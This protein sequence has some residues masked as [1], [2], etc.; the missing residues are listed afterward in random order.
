MAQQRDEPIGFKTVQLLKDQPLG[1]DERERI[2]RPQHSQQVQSLQLTIQ[3]KDQ[4]IL[5][6]DQA[7]RDKDEAI[8]QQERENSI[9]MENKE[10]EL[11]QKVGKIKHLERQLGE[12]ERVIAQLQKRI[13]ELEQRRPATDAIPTSKE[14]RA[15][16][17]REGEK[18]PCKI[19]GSYRAATNY[20]TLCIRERNRAVHAYSISTSSWSKLP[21]SPTSDCPSV[22]INNL[23]TVVGG[24]NGFT[25]TNKLFSLTGEGSARRWTEEFP[26]MPTGRWGSAALVTGTA[27]VVA[28]GKTYETSSLRIVEIM[29]IVTKQW[30]T[31]AALPEPV[32]YAPAAVCGDQIYILGMYTCSVVT[33]VQSCIAKSFLASLRKGDTG[34]WKEVAAPPVTEFTCVS[35]HGRLLAIGGIS[36]ETNQPTADI[37]MYNPTTDSWEVISHMGTPRWE[38]IAAVLP[39]NQLMVVGGK[40]GKAFSTFTDSTELAAIELL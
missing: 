3:E 11:R 37:H 27:L 12:R 21:K 1:S 25:I 33:L 26:P 5:Q 40:T 31:A 18:A 15:L 36:S 30:S 6:K 14:Q 32:I 4:I 8:K 10:R 39:N 22:I 23:F 19:S 34:V 38:C 9:T 24:N 7:L 28:G 17:W 13:A 35:I 2:L 20:E 29:N 16:M